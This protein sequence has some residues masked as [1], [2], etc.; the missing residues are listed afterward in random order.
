MLQ[1]TPVLAQT[2]VSSGPWRNNASSPHRRKSTWSCIS[3][4]CEQNSIVGAPPPCMVSSWLQ[5]SGCT[6]TRRKRQTVRARFM[7]V[8]AGWYSC[9][10]ELVLS[11][12]GGGPFYLAMGQNPVGPPFIWSWIKTQIVAPVNIPILLEGGLFLEGPKTTPLFINHKQV[13]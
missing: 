7:A 11:F 5:A 9:L 2:R 10:W 3:T 8:C 12:V 13:G 6:L 1:V 4:S